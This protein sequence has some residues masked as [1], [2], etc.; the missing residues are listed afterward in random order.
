MISLCTPNNKV[1]API[2]RS[3]P[4]EGQTHS[5]VR[6]I[7]AFYKTSQTGQRGLPKLSCM[8]PIHAQ[9]ESISTAIGVLWVDTNRCIYDTEIVVYSTLL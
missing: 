4:F 7:L 8:D 9:E 1:E 5:K 3:H 2:R 6:P